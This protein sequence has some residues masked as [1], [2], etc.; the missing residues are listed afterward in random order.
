MLNEQDSKI[1]ELFEDSPFK[2]YFERY[3]EYKRGKGY[4]I[5]WSMVYMMK[6]INNLMAEFG[7]DAFT[8]EMAD[9]ILT[10]KMD[11]DGCVLTKMLTTLR[12]FSLFL[13][14]YE[15]GTFI[16]PAGYWA[17]KREKVRT[18]VFTSDELLRITKA[19]DEYSKTCPYLTKH[20]FPPHPFIIRMLIGTGMRIG[21]ILALRRK[22]F[23]FDN[24]VVSVL[25]GKGGVS[26]YV[27]IS[28]T[29]SDS[30]R[31]YITKTSGEDCELVFLSWRT[32]KGISPT[33]AQFL[34]HRFI[35]MAGIKPRGG[36]SPSVHTFRHTFI[37]HTLDRMLRSGM[38]LYTALPIIGAYVGHTNL[39]DVE[40]YVHLTG[41]SIEVFNSR[42]ATLENLLPEVC[43]EDE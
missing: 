39:R 16:I 34:V 17:Q 24:N 2:G 25:D 43:D 42:Q 12:Q 36:D 41:I 29:L 9:Y 33:G 35:D 8:R 13:S 14:M 19:A 4:K 21:E 22:D 11:D 26:R 1:F 20:E 27:P 18:F 5:G 31:L 38:D 23:D 37:T 3:I 28:D 32:G 40:K 7:G 30:M 10:S 6:R 15:P